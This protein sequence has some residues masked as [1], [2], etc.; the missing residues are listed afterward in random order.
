VTS[1]T[2]LIVVGDNDEL[3][4]L[5][6][7]A[8]RGRGATVE[9]CPTARAALAYL[10]SNGGASVAVVDLPLADMRADWFLI[11]LRNRNVPVVAVSG[12]LRGERFAETARR[13]GA[14][15]FLEKPFNI[16][17]L[18]KG[19]GLPPASDEFPPMTIHTTGFEILPETTGGALLP[20]RQ[21]IPATDVPPV[22]ARIQVGPPAWG[23]EPISTPLPA[24]QAS[25]PPIPSQAPAPS[26]FSE[27]PLPA[28]APSPHATAPAAAALLAAAAPVASP[29]ARTP[30]PVRPPPLSR[31]PAPSAPPTAA[32][33]PVAAAPAPTPAPRP[34]A[35]AQPSPPPAPRPPEIPPPAPEL[36]ASPPE[37][38]A[39]AA[40]PAVSPAASPSAS[41]APPAAAARPKR[42]PPPKRQPAAAPP[43]EPPPPAPA[44]ARAESPIDFDSLVFSEARPALDETL[45]PIPIAPKAPE[46]LAMPLPGV[47]PASGGRSTAPALPEGD[48]AKTRVTRLLTSLHVAQVTGALT[49]A[50][51][52][53]KKLVLFDQGRPVFAASNVAFDRF[54]LRCVRE[55]VLTQEALDALSAEIGDAPL[56]QVLVDRG[57]IDEERRARLI[58]DQIRDILWSTFLWREGT[59]RMLVGPRARRPIVAVSIFPGDLVLE[60]LRRTA[61]LENLREEMPDELALAPATDPS[62]ELYDLQILPAEAQMLA[63]ADGTKTVSDL[64]VLSGLS[65]R[66]ARAF[67]QGCRDIGLLDEV[68]RVLAGTR[69]IGFM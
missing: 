14:R 56:N 49:L 27:A 50:H 29:P 11:A 21:L 28:G 63:H 65:E 57:L 6:A 64:M 42:E 5:V 24:P 44:P 69:R 4:Q 31:E 17:R 46:G 23:A 2:R 39:P 9:V 60:G 66:D 15:D 59:Y 30:P 32:A 25:W 8:A 48:L 26:P 45:P 38:S 10:D 7:G 40:S 1:G 16:E 36:A 22:L 3:A 13:F 18:L 54:G 34:A 53:V 58:A 43:P 52:P 67:L 62:F 68:S 47:A 55:G 35:A 51:G 37:P 33:P 19:L 61:T 20:P 41:A 12:V